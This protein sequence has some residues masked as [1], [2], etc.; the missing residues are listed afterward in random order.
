MCRCVAEPLATSRSAVASARG[1]PV[2]S[3]PSDNLPV[4]AGPAFGAATCGELRA[5]KFVGRGGVG[6][7]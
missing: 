1:R 6:V 5:R 2:L 3:S 4:H 7:W